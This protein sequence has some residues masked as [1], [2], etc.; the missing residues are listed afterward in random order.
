MIVALPLAAPC[1][2]QINSFDVDEAVKQVTFANQKDPGNIA[3]HSLQKLA[4]SSRN[5]QR[6][7][8]L[9]TDMFYRSFYHHFDGMV[10]HQTWKIST[11]VVSWC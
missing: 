5:P 10:S 7:T 2:K 3:R 6:D 9:H 11:E 8:I 1:P 4:R